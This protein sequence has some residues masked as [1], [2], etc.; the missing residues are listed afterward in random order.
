MSD[1]AA[2][3]PTPLLPEAKPKKKRARTTPL[4]GMEDERLEKIRDLA[5]AYFAVRQEKLSVAKREA[6]AA[7]ELI[8]ALHAHR[9]KR[10]VDA[11]AGLIVELEKSSEKV[12]VSVEND[13]DE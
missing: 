8:D 3:K 7:V 1:L 9:L 5:L 13:R 2:T 12:R 6:A 4:P 11:E 10:Y